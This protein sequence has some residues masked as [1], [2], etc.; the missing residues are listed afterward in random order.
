MLYYLTYSMV[1]QGDSK[2]SPL[3]WDPIQKIYIEVRSMQHARELD[4]LNEQIQNHIN[5]ENEY[6]MYLNNQIDEYNVSMMQAP[7]IWDPRKNKYVEVNNLED[8]IK[9]DKLNEIIENH[10]KEENKYY[11]YCDNL[12]REYDINYLKNLI[13]KYK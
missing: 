10:E 13:E 8:A 7:L 9:I 6:E 1:D 11:E 2:S 4:E 5:E 12:L 3:R